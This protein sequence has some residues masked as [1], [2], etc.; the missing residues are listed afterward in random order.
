M[1][2]KTK[3]SA[4]PTTTIY[5]PLA[6]RRRYKQVALRIGSTQSGL[7]RDEAVAP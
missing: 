2:S 5:M 1:R 6:L 3:K 4:I 7:I